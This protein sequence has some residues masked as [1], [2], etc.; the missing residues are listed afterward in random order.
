VLEGL[1]EDYMRALK[2]LNISQ[3]VVSTIRLRCGRRF[4]SKFEF[5]FKLTPKGEE[6]ES[7]CYST[8]RTEEKGQHLP[9][10]ASR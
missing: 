7:L 2:F 3:P 10:L 6:S 5:E 8:G 9:F 1:H 4:F